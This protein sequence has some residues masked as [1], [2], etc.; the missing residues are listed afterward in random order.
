MLKDP[1]IG[2]IGQGFIGRNYAVDFESRGYR[3]VRYSQETPY[4]ENREKIRDCDIVFI[5]VPTPTTPSGFD[6][7]IVDEVLSLI[8][9]GKSAVIKS[10]ILPG[11]CAALQAKHPDIFIFHSPEFLTEKNA[12]YDAAHP[13]R[14]VIGL[15]V[16]NEEYRRRAEDI[17]ALLP[18]APLSLVC[19]D[20]EAEIIKYASNCFLFLKVLYAN[21]LCDLTTRAGGDWEKVR[22]GVAADP[23]IGAGHLNPVDTSGLNNQPGRGAGGHC[24]VKDFSALASYLEKEGQD[25]LGSA[26]FRAAEA[27]NI[28]LLKGSGKDLDILQGV[29]GDKIVS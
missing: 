16:D 10:T 18:T 24:F 15:P 5:A 26:F 6:Y 2:L 11:T 29:Y 21:I 19:R 3:T 27:K 14:N 7:S 12:L 17:L 23:R 8:G 9:A 20:T 22:A 13:T 28:S 25:P 4:N 1:L